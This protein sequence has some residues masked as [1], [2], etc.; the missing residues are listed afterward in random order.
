MNAEKRRMNKQE[1]KGGKIK[2]IQGKKEEC[3]KEKQR[4]NPERRETKQTRK[5]GVNYKQLKT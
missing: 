5:G 3:R 1:R 2:T 4:M